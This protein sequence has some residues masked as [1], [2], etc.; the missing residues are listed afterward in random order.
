MIGRS[1]IPGASIALSA[2]L[3]AA[4]AGCASAP[5]GPGNPD[6]PAGAAAWTAALAAAGTPEERASVL[7]ERLEAAVAELRSLPEAEPALL[8]AAGRALERLVRGGLAPAL[9]T[10]PPAEDLEDGFLDSLRERLAGQVLAL[11]GEASERGHPALREAAR[12]LREATRSLE[13][14]LDR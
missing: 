9:R 12:A 1:G 10:L 8:A 13:E 5:A 3:A 4:A 6:F 2:W 11:E 14:A 7:T